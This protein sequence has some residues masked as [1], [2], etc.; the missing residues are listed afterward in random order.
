MT[1]FRH[2]TGFFFSLGTTLWLLGLLLVILFA[3]ALIMPGRQEF[4][5]I[6]SI[7]MFEWLVKQPL[8]ITWW[9]WSLTLVLLVL[10][11]NTIFCSADSIIRKRKVTRWL[12]LISPQIIHIGFLFILLAHLLSAFGSSQ[13]F[14]AAGEG[15]LLK[16]SENNT[17][18]HVRDINIYT[19]P[20][21]HI[22]GWEVIVEYLADGKPFRRDNIRPN[23]PSVQSGLNII[24]KD[25]RASPHR[26]V[27]LQINRE[28]GAFW[29]LA[30]GILLIAGI[31]ILVVLRIKMER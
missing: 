26:A 31:V 16:L 2:I 6:H 22:S 15:S 8:A 9:M 28:P 23:K 20:E 18:L 21:G 12:L 27:L 25:F 30:G 5:N 14:A 1:L 19:G 11:V 24:A 7:P 4:Q 29:A 17:V 10:A 13:T 3:G